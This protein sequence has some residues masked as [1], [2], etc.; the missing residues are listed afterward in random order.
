MRVKDKTTPYIVYLL[1]LWPTTDGEAEVW[2]ASLECPGSGERHGFAN[3][4]ALF[5]FLQAQVDV[6]QRAGML[7]E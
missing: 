2:R 3:L 7:S 6:E 4:D 1:R 5:A